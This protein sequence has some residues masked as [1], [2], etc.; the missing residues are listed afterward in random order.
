MCTSCVSSNPTATHHASKP[1]NPHLTYKAKSPHKS[2]QNHPP[3]KS[4]K[5]NNAPLQKHHLPKRR[6]RAPHPLPPPLL[7]KIMVPRRIPTEKKT[8]AADTAVHGQTP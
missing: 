3:T 2:Q 7:Q 8:T 5:S 1:T 4:A 6:P